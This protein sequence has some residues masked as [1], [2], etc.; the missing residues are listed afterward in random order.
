MYEVDI[1]TALEGHNN[2]KKNNNLELIKIKSNFSKLITI[3]ENEKNNILEQLENDMINYESATFKVDDVTK[4][5][6]KLLEDTIKKI[7]VS[8]KGKSITITK[9]KTKPL[10]ITTL[11]VEYGKR[12]IT[13]VTEESVMLKLLEVYGVNNPLD[14]TMTI[15]KVFHLAFDRK[16]KLSTNSTL[17]FRRNLSTYNSYFDDAFRKKDIRKITK[18]DLVM[19]TNSMVSTLHPSKKEFMAYKGILNMIFEYAFDKD[20]RVDNPVPAIHNE[21]YYKVGYCNIK[22]REAEDFIL[23]QDEIISIREAL[24]ERSNE[25]RF[26]G[27]DYN[28]YAI[29]FSTHTGVRSD[30]VC[31]LKWS[32][33]KD[34]FIWIHSQIVENRDEN[35][36]TIW[37][38]VPYTK[39]ERKKPTK[40]G[41]YFPLDDDIRAL[42][43]EVKEK[44]LEKG[45]FDKDGYVFARLN[46]SFITPNAYRKSLE[47]FMKKHGYHITRNHVFRMSLNSNVLVPL[48]Y[49]SVQRAYLLGH[50]PKVNEDNYTFKRLDDSNEIYQ[51]FQEK[52]GLVQT[53]SK[54]NV[55]NINQYKKEKALENT[56]FPK[57]LS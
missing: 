15:D 5:E 12:Q 24:I 44:Q 52:N 9:H 20:I 30:E 36:N 6:R 38:Y 53:K 40:T 50:S 42:L 35:N 41:R 10:Y 28:G 1:M 27:Y 23:P 56:T 54:P 19:Y 11:P 49:D 25:K 34:Y 37:E 4:K 29:R 48:G 17:S 13:G 22:P 31:S 43:L 7:H 39:N 47:K 33:I 8:S 18:D 26:K 21:N 3:Y 16:K 51:K 46:G 2:L 14:K 45:I 55:T 32:D 57:T